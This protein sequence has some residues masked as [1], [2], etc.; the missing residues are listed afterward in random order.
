MIKLDGF[1]CPNFIE[2]L[3]K[4]IDCANFVKIK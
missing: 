4:Q 2:H 3:W 1:G